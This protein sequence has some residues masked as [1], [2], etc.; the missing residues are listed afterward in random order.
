MLLPILKRKPVASAATVHR[1]RKLVYGT[2]DVYTDQQNHMR[3]MR[4]ASRS[5]VLPLEMQWYCRSRVRNSYR[6]GILRYHA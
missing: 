6:G 4:C 3:F 1:S 5:I 2:W